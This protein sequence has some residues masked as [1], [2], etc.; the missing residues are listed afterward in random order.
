MIF[1]IIYIKK[2]LLAS[3]LVLLKVDNDSKFLISFSKPFLPSI[4]QLLPIPLL[5]SSTF[6][7]FIFLG[8]RPPPSKV[9][10]SSLYLSP[11]SLSGLLLSCNGLKLTIKTELFK[12]ASLILEFLLQAF[13]IIFKNSSVLFSLTIARKYLLTCSFV[14][15]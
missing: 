8:P 12:V 10:P 1:L 5:G 9:D 4:F 7:L 15:K 11:P 14:V 6:L 3:S 13:S 2:G